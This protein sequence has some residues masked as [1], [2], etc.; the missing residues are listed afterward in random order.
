MNEPLTATKQ[1]ISQIF[2]DEFVEGT[3]FQL[4]GAH[5]LWLDQLGFKRAIDQVDE[6]VSPGDPTGH[7]VVDL[8]AAYVASSGHVNAHLGLTSSDIIDNVRLIQIKQALIEIRDAVESF[9]V[10][11][12]PAFDAEIDA[13]GFTHW[14]PAAPIE[15]R[16]RLRAW[17]EPLNLLCLNLP[18][19]HAKRFGGPVGDGASLDLIVPDWTKTPFN[20]GT[21]DLDDPQNNF[22]LQSSDYLDETAA[23]DWLGAVAAQLHKIAQDLR[24]LMS[25]D[26]VLVHQSAGHAGSS[27]MPHKNNPHKW[28]KVCSICRSVAMHKLEIWE[29]MAMNS[30][31]RTLDGSWQIKRALKNAFENVAYALDEMRSVSCSINF[32]QNLNMLFQ[33]RG[34]IF[35]DRDLTRRV[36]AGESRWTAYREMLQ[37]HQQ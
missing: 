13:V 11:F 15:W 36:L 4:W 14:R 21:F 17:V 9:I 8:L 25:H 22:P 12:S 23:I 30:M 26:L 28:E 16:H 5:L 18:S 33:H 24:F 3:C 10:F 20:W 37:Q 1:K 19:V 31:E 27:S 32:G 34:S 7:E 35:S 29:V 6:N 2:S